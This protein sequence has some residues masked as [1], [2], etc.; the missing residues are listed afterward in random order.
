MD[1]NAFNHGPRGDS[2]E[3]FGVS[4]AGNS[5]GP[6]EPGRRRERAAKNRQHMMTKAI[7]IVFVD[8]ALDGNT[9]P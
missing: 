1:G 8:G 3:S 6:G 4:S 9:S 5:N 2:N 7:C